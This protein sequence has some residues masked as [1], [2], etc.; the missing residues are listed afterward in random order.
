ML[1]MI[2]GGMG[3]TDATQIMTSLPGINLT[4]FTHQCLDEEPQ[5]IEKSLFRTPSPPL[6]NRS[7]PNQSNLIFL[8]LSR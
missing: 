8:A 4:W 2:L 6:R 5:F 7:Q 1:V 3:E